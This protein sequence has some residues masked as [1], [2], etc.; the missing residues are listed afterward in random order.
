MWCVIQVASGK[1]MEVKEQLEKNNYKAYVP[2]ENRLIRSKGTFTQKEYVLFP[3]YIFL[4]I[5]YNAEN[6]YR[7]KEV[8][9]VIKFLGEALRPDTLSTVEIEWIKVLA[10]GGEA[11][12]PAKIVLNNEGDIIDITGVA[13]CF[14]NRI[15][16]INKH[17]KKTEFEITLCGEVKKIE[18]SAEITGGS[19]KAEE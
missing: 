16:K 2:R 14:R 18:L 6:Y 17:S 11:I 13:G 9:G 19:E 3:G 12:E 5:N 4:D 7:I 1:E 15:T 8:L 10:N